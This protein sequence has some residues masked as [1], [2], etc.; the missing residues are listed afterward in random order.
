MATAVLGGFGLASGVAHATSAT[1]VLSD[2]AHFKAIAK[3]TSVQL[4]YSFSSSSCSLT[5]DGEKNVF[6]C[7]LRGLVMM[8]PASGILTGTATLSSADG[9]TTGKYSLTPTS[10]PNT[11]QLKGTCTEHDTADPGGKPATYP[12]TAGGTIVAVPQPNG[13]FALSG[14]L[15]IFESS[16]AP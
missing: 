2:V 11:Y 15:R 14:T 13:T 4:Q 10:Q 12:C 9:T 16:T 1:S 7:V 5:S 6:P 3:P 8:N